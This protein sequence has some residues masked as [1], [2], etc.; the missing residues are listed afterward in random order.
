MRAL[1]TGAGGFVGGHLCAYLLAH[2]DWELLGTVYPHPVESQ[3]EEPRLRLKFAN[4]CDPGGARALFD[5]AQPDYIFHLAAQ[6]FVP[7]S[8]ADPWDTLQNNIRSELN[9]LEAVR[10]SGRDVRVLVIGSNE[11]YGAPRPEE[12]PQTEQSP[13]RPNNP[14]AVSKVA[15]DFL[16]LQYHLAYGL[17]VVRVR[18]F[19]HTGPGQSPRFVVPAFASQIARIE[20]GQQE[21]VMKVG[22]LAAARDFSDVRDI[23]RAYHLAATQGEAG[24][25]YNLAS[26]KAQSI[27]GLLDTLLG[28]SQAEIRV[29][30]DPARYRPVDVPEVYGSALKFHR[31][32]GWEPEI[33]FEQTLRDTLEYWRGQVGEHGHRVSR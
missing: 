16:G 28:Y 17:P 33:P 13:L 1:V 14:Y 2:T 21:P 24:E 31:L 19:N 22:N 15:Q 12:L 30:R 27:Q 26:G 20:A 11:E 8:F 5:A 3:P 23:V 10:Q 7:T 32:T 18:P 29:E 25:V 6:A 4:L 9:L